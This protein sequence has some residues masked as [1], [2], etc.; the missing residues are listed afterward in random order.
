MAHL[1]AGWDYLGWLL[2]A[3]LSDLQRCLGTAGLNPAYGRRVVLK[4]LLLHPQHRAG[5]EGD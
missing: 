3:T 5:A 2:P 4:S 1:P